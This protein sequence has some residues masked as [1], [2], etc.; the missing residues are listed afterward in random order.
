MDLLLA[1]E[2]LP[3]LEAFR[4]SFLVYPAVS[5]LHIMGFATLFVCVMLMDLRIVGAIQVLDREVFVTLMRRFAIAGFTVAALT[6]LPM[7]AVQAREYVFNP[8]FQA[9]MALLVLAALNLW[10]FRRVAGG[11]RTQRPYPASARFLAMTSI[12]IW[13]ALILTGRLVGFI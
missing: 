11:D 8:A 2:T 5:A 10:A 6:G 13:I 3:P 9:K 1:I 7:F 12:L 4:L